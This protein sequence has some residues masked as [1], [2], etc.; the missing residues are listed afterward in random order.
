MKMEQFTNKKGN[1]MDFWAKKKTS[2]AK[3]TSYLFEIIAHDRK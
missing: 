2:P 3:R 1:Q